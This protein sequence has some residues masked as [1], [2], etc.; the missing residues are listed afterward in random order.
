ML[1]VVIVL[2]VSDSVFYTDAFKK[3][4]TLSKRSVLLG[5]PLVS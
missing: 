3:I 4:S 5:C 2:A 1:V